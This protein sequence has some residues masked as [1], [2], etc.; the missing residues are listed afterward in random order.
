M[1]RMLT[2][3]LLAL[4]VLSL[5]GAQETVDAD[6]LK[7]AGVESGQREQAMDLFRQATGRTAVLRADLRI[8]EAELAKIVA[9]DQVDLPAVEKKLRE[10]ADLEM[11]IRLD[12][13][14]T[15][16]ELRDLIGKERWARFRKNL[17]DKMPEKKP[18]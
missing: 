11:A 17:R 2:G 15:E 14:R 7:K 3:S 8:K 4:L 9:A 1:K 5:A 16:T 6:E 12:R 13:I 10:I 18:R